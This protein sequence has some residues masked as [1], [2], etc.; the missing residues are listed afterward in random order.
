[1]FIA[2]I[3]LFINSKKWFGK[4]ATAQPIDW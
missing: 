2:G 4:A 3:V 1:L